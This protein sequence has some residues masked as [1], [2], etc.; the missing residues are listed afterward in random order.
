MWSD[1]LAIVI[2]ASTNVIYWNQ[3][4]GTT[5]QQL[6]A[7]GYLVPIGGSRFNPDNGPINSEIL[8]VAFHNGRRCTYGAL[9]GG[10]PEERLE[11][12]SQAVQD[13]PYWSSR[14]VDGQC[15]RQPLQ[16]DESRMFQ[17]CEAWVPVITPDGAGTLMWGNCD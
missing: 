8:T 13:I 11:R 9:A 6:L 2:E 12:L 1:W 16:L 14:S 17:M 15:S 4:G 10:L 5:C 7:E 3:C